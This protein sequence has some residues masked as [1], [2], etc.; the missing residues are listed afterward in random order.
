[1]QKPKR[2]LLLYGS[3]TGK[4]QSIAELIA[5]LAAKKGFDADLQCLD[6]FGKTVGQE[7]NKKSVTNVVANLLFFSVQHL[8]RACVGVGELDDGRRRPA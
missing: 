8:R 4:A 1:M 5:D 3:V 7:K 2:F 6:G